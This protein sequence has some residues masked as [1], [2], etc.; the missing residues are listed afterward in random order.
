MTDALIASL[1]RLAGGARTR[2]FKSE[3]RYTFSS[4]QV[5]DLD[6]DE[7]REFLWQVYRDH[8]L[9][10]TRGGELVGEVTELG[11]WPFPHDDAPADAAWIGVIWTPEAWPL[12]REGKLDGLRLAGRPVRVG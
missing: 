3:D 1:D 2:I 6:P 5:P 8:D 12:A 9:R 7:E 11:R 4:M 10:L